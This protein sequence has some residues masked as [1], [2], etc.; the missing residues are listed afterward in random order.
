MRM[1]PDTMAFTKDVKIL[2]PPLG[3]AEWSPTQLPQMSKQI[4]TESLQK[5]SYVNVILW[6][7]LR[8]IPPILRYREVRRCPSSGLFDDVEA[9][10]VGERG[11]LLHQRHDRR[12]NSAMLFVW[13]EVQNCARGGLGA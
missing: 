7:F 2:M 11:A 8:V 1:F 12:D 5:C 10:A 3:L 6:Y 4:F 9:V 13:S